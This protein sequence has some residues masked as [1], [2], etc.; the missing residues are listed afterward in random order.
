MIVKT[1]IIGIIIS[2][3]VSLSSITVSEAGGEKVKQQLQ[4]SIQKQNA[5]TEKLRK[6]LNELR[7][8]RKP[9]VIPDNVRI[10]RKK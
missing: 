5:N 8:L 4:E 6:S 9:L 10:K 7:E 2:S 1:I 3:V